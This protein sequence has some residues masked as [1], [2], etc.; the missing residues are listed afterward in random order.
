MTSISPRGVGGDDDFTRGIAPYEYHSLMPASDE[1]KNALAIA[2][3]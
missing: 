2:S 3:L 1:A